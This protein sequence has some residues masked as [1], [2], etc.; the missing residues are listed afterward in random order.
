MN[1]FVTPPIVEATP[2]IP[3]VEV[4]SPVSLTAAD[5]NADG[6]VDLVAGYAASNKIVWFSHSLAAKSGKRD[7]I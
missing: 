3:D 5:L 4:Q 1:E 7:V 6:L 2:P